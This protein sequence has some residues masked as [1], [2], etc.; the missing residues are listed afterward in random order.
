MQRSPDALHRCISTAIR[1]YA[2]GDAFGVHY[3]FKEITEVTPELLGLEDWPF[4][5]VSD[6]TFLSLIT[7]A[8]LTH[9]SPS[10]SAE[11]FLAN[12]KDAAP[13]LRGLGP[14]TRHAL[15]M[16]V[17]ESEVHLIGKS[18]GA[19]MRTALCGLAFLIADATKRREFIGALA[20]ATHS[21]DEAILA[22]QIA[23][24]LFSHAIS[25]E[26]TLTTSEI[27]AS[28]LSTFNIS[29]ETSEKFAHRSQWIAPGSGISLDPIE[30][31]FAFT[32]VADRNEEVLA[33]YMDSCSLGGDT[34]TV[35]ALSGALVAARNPDS[36]AFES[37]S[38]LDQIGWDEISHMSEIIDLVFEKR[39]TS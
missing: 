23:A 10:K 9:S 31:L 11:V 25:S 26:S 28:E 2:A 13:T 30:T 4:G 6:D 16:S 15:G 20:R 8:T 36:S 29:Q 35:G 34:D 17:K 33:A 21:S 38:W 19:M 32:C 12:L 18:N 7:L 1:A 22:A 3:E 5:G 37:I 14:T 24:A 27:I 39:V